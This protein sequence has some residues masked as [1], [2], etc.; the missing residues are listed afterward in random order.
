MRIGF[1]DVCFG[2]I[3][4]TAEDRKRYHDIIDIALDQDLYNTWTRYP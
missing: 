1:T 3:C 2:K 4:C